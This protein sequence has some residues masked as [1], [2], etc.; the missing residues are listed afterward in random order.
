MTS[1]ASHESGLVQYFAYGS[2]MDFDQLKDRCSSATYLSRAVLPDHSICFPRYSKKRECGV[3]S[4]MPQKGPAVWGV[5]YQI[6]RGDLVELDLAEGVASDA[7][8]KIEVI[9]HADGDY[10]LPLSVLTYLAT[11]QAGIYRPSPSYI[12]QFI[13]GARH[14]KLPEAYVHEL[15]MIETEPE[16]E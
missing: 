11:P 5:V 14:W 15:E 3:A 6:N 1:G 16:F 13:K 7:Y 8:G 4:I 10:A 9:V 12:S 2:N